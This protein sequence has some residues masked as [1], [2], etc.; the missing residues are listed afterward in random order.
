MNWMMLIGIALLLLGALMIIVALGFLRRLGG[1]GK[2]RFGGVVLLGP[3]PIIFGDKNLA[4]ILLIF[5]AVFLI[6]FVILFL[7]H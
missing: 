4:S 3:I 7:I 1:S 6:I 2:T 5:A